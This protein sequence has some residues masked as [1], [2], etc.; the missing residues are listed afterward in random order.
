MKMIV[1]HDP[2]SMKPPH[3]MICTR[4]YQNLPLNKKFC[5]KDKHN[6]ENK[7]SFTSTR[8]LHLCSQPHCTSSLPRTVCIQADK[9][10][11]PVMQSKL[12]PEKK[13]QSML[14]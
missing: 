8:F 6:F 2:I 1:L 9:I 13:E 11:L 3:A 10:T 5:C 7:R 12:D 14:L 4:T